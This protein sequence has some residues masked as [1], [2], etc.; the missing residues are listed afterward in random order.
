MRPVRI[1]ALVLLTAAV[2]SCG[3]GGGG[4]GGPVEGWLKIVL[5]TPN[6]GDGAILFRIQGGPIEEIEGGTMMEDG[7]FNQFSSFMR[8]VVAGPLV[9]GDLVY[10]HVPDIG[11]LSDYTATIEQVAA[12]APPH[13]QRSLTGYS[14]TI[15]VDD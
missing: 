15:A 13:A 8:V 11:D 2:T 4:G 1:L 7:S 14:L 12:N 3:G 10:I 5:D 9:D 6:A